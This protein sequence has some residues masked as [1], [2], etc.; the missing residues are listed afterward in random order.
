MKVSR[1]TLVT[2]STPVAKLCQR[3]GEKDERS[4]IRTDLLIPQHNPLPMH[5]SGPARRL[6]LTEG[7]QMELCH[8]LLVGFGFI[9]RPLLADTFGYTNGGGDCGK[10]KETYHCDIRIG[11]V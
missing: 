6:G 2:K 11:C 8:A 9:L 3:S 10:G 7:I 4:R 5:L 1:Q